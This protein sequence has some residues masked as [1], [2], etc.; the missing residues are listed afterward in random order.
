MKI[1]VV[2]QKGELKVSICL[3]LNLPEDLIKAI[4]IRIIT[5]PMRL[6]RAVSMPALNDLIF[7]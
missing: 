3:K 4:E 6:D 7:W 2:P 5:S 1:T